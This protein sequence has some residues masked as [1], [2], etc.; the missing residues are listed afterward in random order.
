MTEILS[1]L[2]PGISTFFAVEANIA[3][4]RLALIALGFL[5]AYLG[6]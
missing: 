1:Q 4:A 5:L 2:F 6:F 3:I